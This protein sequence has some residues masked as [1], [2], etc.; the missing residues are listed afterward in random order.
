MIWQ[1]TKI[2]AERHINIATLSCNRNQRGVEAFIT[3][4]LKPNRLNEKVDK[5]I[6]DAM[7]AEID[8][9]LSQQMDQILHHPAIQKLESTWR[10]LKFAV[11]RTDF[12][13]NIRIEMLNCSKEDLQLDFEDAPEVTKSGLYKIAYSAEFGQFGGK[14]YGAIVRDLIRLGRQPFYHAGLVID[15]DRSMQAD[16]R[17]TLIPLPPSQ[18]IRRMVPRDFV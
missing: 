4:L 18:Y 13:E 15:H 14:P 17:R 2:L 16:Y 9:K 11:D 12:R 8:K 3:E 1:V 6:A 7:I 10:G 5:S